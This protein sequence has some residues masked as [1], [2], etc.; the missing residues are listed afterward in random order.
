MNRRLGGRI[1]VQS[2][3]ERAIGGI[4]LQPVEQ[5]LEDALIAHFKVRKQEG[6]VGRL[7]FFQLR[8]ELQEGLNGLLTI[9]QD[10]FH[11]IVR[12]ILGRLPDAL[13]VIGKGPR[14]MKVPE[15]RDQIL[16]EIDAVVLVILK[17][18]TQQVGYSFL[19][20]VENS[21][22]KPLVDADVSARR[23]LEQI[24]HRNRR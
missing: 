23:G 15:D 22:N 11:Q 8:S 1:A 3:A 6:N 4:V 14:C 2:Q 21:A 5:Q 19:T 24:V 9:R 17:S 13:N 7:V 18:E 10:A 20:A 12:D 16:F